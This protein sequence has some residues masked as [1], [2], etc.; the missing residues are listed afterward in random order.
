MNTH[1][2]PRGFHLVES[3]PPVVE[4]GLENIRSL[5]S[6]LTLPY[7]GNVTGRLAITSAMLRSL[8]VQVHVKS[9]QAPEPS[10][11]AEKLVM[12]LLEKAASLREWKDTLE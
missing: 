3:A 2:L 9:L 12:L 11:R 8:A 5:L 4:D 7:S 10:P 6:G 1:T